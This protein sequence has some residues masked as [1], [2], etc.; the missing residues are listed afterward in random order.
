MKFGNLLKMMTPLEMFLV[1]AFVLYIVLPI[2]TPKEIA[3]AID[4]PLGI[5]VLFCITL[6]LFLYMNPVLGVLY[7]FVAYQLLRRSSMVTLKSAVVEHAP[8][9]AKRDA[10]MQQAQ[11]PA[12]MHLTLEE[13]VVAQRAPLVDSQR[14]NAYLESD[15]KP[16]ADLTI[17]GASLVV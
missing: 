6:Y 11:P 1:L 17:P 12:N 15:F 10:V 2:N 7:I 4:S 8:S 9:Q 3:G 16:V 5:L 13:E 14:A